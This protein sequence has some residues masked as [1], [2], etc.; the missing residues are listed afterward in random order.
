[1]NSA[2]FFAVFAALALFYTLLGFIAA[3][4]IKTTSDYFLAGRNLSLFAVTLTLIATQVGSGMLVGTSQYAYLYGLYGLLYTIGMAAGFVILGIGLASKLQSL[5]VATTAELFETRYGSPTLKIIASLLSVIMMTGILIGQVVGSRLIIETLKLGSGN[6]LIF[7]G[8]WIFVILYTMVGGLKA[9]VITDIF[10]VLLIIGIFA[11]IFFYSVLFGPP[12]DWS[13]IFSI[14]REQ[15]GALPLSMNMLIATLFM[16][17][18]FSLIEQD[19]AQRFFAARTKRIATVSA[20]LTAAFMIIF[21]LVPIYF[22]MQAKLLG[23][24]IPAGTS[25]LIATI[26]LLTNE[27]VVILALCAIKI[28][29]AS[30]RERV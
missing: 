16:P 8:F 5:N 15:F 6:E 18:L 25:P 29:R 30:C 20:L 4:K 19:L 28:G 13:S 11:A 17:I 26:E 22:G 27:F 9:V 21:A 3:K 7:I 10:Q 24:A 14:Q 12:F 1:M 23:I 2:L